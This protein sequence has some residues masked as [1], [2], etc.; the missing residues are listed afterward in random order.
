MFLLTATPAW[1]Q[2][3]P[4]G[5][6]VAGSMRLRYETID[7]QVRPGFN[8]SDA[9][10]DLR[11]I[12][13]ATWKAGPIRIGGELH[14]S[15]SWLANNGTPLSTN[16][17][18]AV[19]PVQA[20][21]AADIAR[22]FGPGTTLALQGGRF[23]LNIGSR[24]LV[25]SDDYR[26]TTNG[27]TG[28]RADLGLHRVKA[29]LFYVLPLT[30]LPDDLPSLRAN[31]IRLDREN[32]DHVLWGGVA[33]WRRRPG[34]TMAEIGFIHFG[35]RDAP[36]RPTRNRSLNSVTARAISEPCAGAVDY[37]VEGIYQSGRI[38]ADLSP[39][40]ARLPVSAW[41]GRAEIG[42]TLGGG[43]KPRLSAQFDI[44]SGD[45]PGGTYTRFDTLYG[46]RRADLGPVGI[47]NVVA[48]TNVVT[49]GLRLEA[50]PGKRIDLMV[51]YRLLW[52]AAARD[53][54]AGT[55]VR[56][57]SG[58]SGSFAGRQ[59]DARVR[60]W[61]VP[62]RLRFEVDGEWLAKGRFLRDAPNAPR[63]GDT[64]YLSFNLTASF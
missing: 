62:Q 64:T 28:L 14:D 53:S 59:L 44:A 60:T 19:E 20:W 40:A 34:A 46:M 48:R 8:A 36:G 31:R 57:A 23:S 6:H 1:A 61:I 30:R 37:E 35:E 24:R 4:D 32:F 38:S 3:T 10:I 39:G 47:Y 5:L 26:N 51:N 18:N 22:P 2:A 15:R 11:T 50:A 9:L 45:R 33:S 52:L 21:I 54:F 12:L 43:W 41:F 7:G 27:Y 42:Y 29:S 13:A 49:P 58:G 25:A 56:D 55:G 16:E 17:V 63:D